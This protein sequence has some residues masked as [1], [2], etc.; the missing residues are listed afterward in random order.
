MY[1]LRNLWLEGAGSMIDLLTQVQPYLNYQE[2]LLVEDIERNKWLGNLVNVHEVLH[3]VY[4][5]FEHVFA[6]PEREKTLTPI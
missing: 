3:I 2:N 6:L 1:V 4:I 5:Y